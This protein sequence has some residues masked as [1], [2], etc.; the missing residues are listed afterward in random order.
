[1]TDR[2]RHITT[3]YAAALAATS[4]LLAFAPPAPAQTNG[5]LEATPSFLDVRPAS[6]AKRTLRIDGEFGRDDA[7]STVRVERQRP[8]GTWDHVATAV[9]DADGAFVARWLTD[10]PGRY[11]LRAIVERD[12]GAAG[13]AS[14]GELF[15]RISVFAAATASWYGPGFWGRRTACGTRLRRGTVGV[16][17]RTLPCGTR[18]EIYHRNRTVV[19]PVI[20]RGPF[21]AGRQWDLTQAAAEAIGLR[22]TARV[23]ILP[24]G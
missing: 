17:H 13:A 18:V 8:D 16:A 5:G 20:D 4:A 23:G 7:G 15:A 24:A 14:T 19:V 21:I 6:L 22:A 10:A 11:A 3:R 9:T 1:M 2:R 12:P